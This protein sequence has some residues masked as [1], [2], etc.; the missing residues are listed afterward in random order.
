ME[1]AP[2]AWQAELSERH[3]YDVSGSL[4]EQVVYTKPPLQAGVAWASVPATRTLYYPAGGIWQ[5]TT[6]S[7]PLVSSSAGG[8]FWSSV[9]ETHEERDAGDAIMF[10]ESYQAYQD[11]G[12]WESYRSRVDF[13][14]GGFATLPCYITYNQQGDEQA[15]T[16]SP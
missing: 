2:G 6:Y 13:Y 9:R 7:S 11:Q 5:L 10:T 8:S 12:I 16:C 14:Q 3:G 1:T 15:N 4:Q